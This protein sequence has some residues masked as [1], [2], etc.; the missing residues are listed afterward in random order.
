MPFIICSFNNIHLQIFNR[1]DLEICHPQPILASSFNM[2]EMFFI[3]HRH[4]AV[5]LFCTKQK[6]GRLYTT[7][8]T[9]QSCSK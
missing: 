7:R 4:L 8:K 1:I 6:A 2:D 3:T 5:F 9:K